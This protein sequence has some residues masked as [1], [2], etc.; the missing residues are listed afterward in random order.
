[1]GDGLTGVLQVCFHVALEGNIAHL[2]WDYITLPRTPLYYPR[3]VYS[4]EDLAVES[5]F[6]L[7]SELFHYHVNRGLVVITSKEG[8]PMPGN[9]NF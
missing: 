4:L 2:S 5:P 8:L 6:V 3:A 7:T 1:M 9:M